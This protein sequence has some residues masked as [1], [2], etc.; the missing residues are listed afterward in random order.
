MCQLQTCP[1]NSEFISHM[2]I[3]NGQTSDDYVSIYTP[4]INPPQSKMSL[5]ALVYISHHWHMPKQICLS[6]NTSLPHCPNNVVYMWTPYL[7]HT[8]Q[9]TTKCISYLPSYNHMFQQ[10]MYSSNNTDM[11]QIQG[12]CADITLP[13]Q[14]MYLT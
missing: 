3:V 13:Y 10:Q 6:S 4:H 11:P 9:N 5:E 2:P 12:L 7:A 8:S 14:Y 1:S